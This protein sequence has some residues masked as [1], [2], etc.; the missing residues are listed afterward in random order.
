[1]KIPSGKVFRNDAYAK[2]TGKAKYSDDLKFFN[3]AHAVPVYSDYIHAENLQVDT[4]AAE[5]SA[6]VLKVITAA[7]V[8]GSIRFGQIDQDYCMFAEKKIMCAGDVVALVVAEQRSQ[9]LSAA[10]KV[11]ISADPLPVVSDPEAALSPESPIVR[12]IENSNLMNHH[13]MRRGD[14]PQEL[15]NCDIVL[16][17]EF[18]TQFIEHAYMEP[19]SAVCVPRQDGVME[20]YGSMQ[21][22]F[23]TRRFVGALLGEPLSHIEVYQPPTGGGFGGK[24]DTAAIVCA[25]AALAARL[26]NRPV[27]LTYTREWSI[28]ESYKRHPYR[29]NYKVGIE[30]SGRVKAV[31]VRMISDGGPYLSVSPWV[32]W[33]STAQCFGPYTVDN[34]HADVLCVATNNPVTGAMRGFGAPQVNFAVEQISDIAAERLGISP[35]EYRRIN[36]VKQD[37]ETVT[38][39]VLD[40]HTVSMEQVMDRVAGEIAYEEKLGRCSRGTSEG[41][42][43][44]GVGLSISYRGSS[45]GAEGMDFC[46][47][48]I[49]CQFDGSILLE[50]GIHENGQGAES[51]MLML[52][53]EQLGVRLDRIKYK[54]SST[55]NVP[56]GGTTVATR[57]TIMGGGAVT[58]AVQKLKQLMADNLYDVLQC[59]PEEVRFADDHVLG[60][61]SDSKITWDEAMQHLFLKRVYPYAFGSFQA[62]DVSWDEE[63]GQGDAYFTYV[64]SCQAVELTVNKSTGKIKLQN[65]VAAHDIGRAVNRAMVL[66]QMYGGITQGIGMALSEDL[67]IENG[68]FAHLDLNHYK[69]PKARELPEM[70]G[71]IVENPDPQSPSKAKG[72]GEPA[73]EL[74]APAIANAVYNATGIRYRDMP[75]KVNPEDLK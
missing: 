1:M 27:K 70:T 55:S 34:V 49:N 48:V 30:K 31:Q 72:I 14:A 16:Q 23:S 63:T 32:N 20:V 39:Q 40:T 3:M 61:D 51:V 21:H 47:S 62:P 28:R 13:K 9:A 26:L 4:G 53:A 35:L 52:L 73:L 68:K 37:G 50:T 45:L 25:R 44:Y 12:E 75:L 41:D 57:G 2:V 11:V 18:S 43:L 15:K 65:V 58:A 74:I 5:K 19:E 60:P 46:S 64:Y 8:P 42:E 17:E 67:E 33:R 6:G 7:D 36:M 54:R 59:R 38:G 69:I 22:P 24:D 71:I 56:D 10:E 66:G 29:L